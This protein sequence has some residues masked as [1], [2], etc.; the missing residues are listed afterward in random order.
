[1]IWY[2]AGPGTSPLR[3]SPAP[4]G[5]HGDGRQ[6]DL[7]IVN[8]VPR[9]QAV[10]LG[11]DARDGGGVLPPDHDAIR[12][13]A[14]QVDLG[15]PAFGIYLVLPAQLPRGRLLEAG[16]DEQCLERGRGAIFAE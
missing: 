1:M 16:P 11:L 15:P 3:R 4:A 10:V 8:R 9:D 6:G 5:E 2:V 14:R 12:A 7:A 13:H